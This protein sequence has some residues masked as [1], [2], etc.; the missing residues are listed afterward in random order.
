M[1]DADGT[2]GKNCNGT[3]RP[4]M[5]LGLPRTTP[6]ST[7]RG[8]LSRNGSVDGDQHRHDTVEHCAA[9]RGMVRT[10]LQDGLEEPGASRCTT[11]LAAT[12]G[13]A[14]RGNA[15]TD[16]TDKCYSQGLMDGRARPRRLR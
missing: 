4:C 10:R 16:P 14:K 13:P 6:T 11:P 3:E 9:H 2:R 1:H 8:R 15:S 12:P 5:S 7:T